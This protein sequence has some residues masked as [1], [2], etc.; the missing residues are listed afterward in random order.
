M[1]RDPDLL[2]VK[3]TA[4]AFGLYYSDFFIVDRHNDLSGSYWW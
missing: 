4:I 1:P 3:I 2:E